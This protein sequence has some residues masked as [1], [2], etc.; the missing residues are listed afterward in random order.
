MPF[1]DR[2]GVLY[3][4]FVWRPDSDSWKKACDEAHD[5]MEGPRIRGRVTLTRGIACSTDTVCIPACLPCV[6]LT[7]LL[8]GPSNHAREDDAQEP[9]ED[10][11]DMQCFQQLSNYASRTFSCFKDF[12]I[13]Y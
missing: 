5:A 11:T 3:C 10:L 6:K 7:Q 4:V 2:D 1:T 12:S 9:A 13:A 8:Q